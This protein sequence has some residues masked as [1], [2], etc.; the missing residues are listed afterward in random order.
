[1]VTRPRFLALSEFGPRSLIYHEGNVFRVVRAKLNVG[2]EDSVST[3]SRLATVSARICPAC[4]Y[5]HIG[6]VLKEE[7][8]QNVCD[9]C[10]TAL[11]DDGRIADLYRV[12]T[13]ETFPVERINANDEERRRQ[14]YELQTTYS[15]T[16]DAFGGRCPL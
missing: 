10:G 5:C 1:M 9:H 15:H 16:R 13:V 7:P 2:T 12:E 8:I 6:S 3:S 11:S 14:G 4:G